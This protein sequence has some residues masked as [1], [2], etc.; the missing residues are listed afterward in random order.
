MHRILLGVAIETICDLCIGCVK[1]LTGFAKAR[2]HS[3]VCVKPRMDGRTDGGERT[4]NW[5]LGNFKEI[6]HVASN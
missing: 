6:F 4:E 1:F 3:A 2:R 5:K